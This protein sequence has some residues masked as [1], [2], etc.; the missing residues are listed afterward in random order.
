MPRALAATLLFGFLI[1]ADGA[2]ATDQT[3]EQVAV[4]AVVRACRLDAIRYCG[5]ATVRSA[6]NGDYSAVVPC[7]Q[8]YEPHLRESCRAVVSQYVR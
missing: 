3:P 5:L 4:N 7:F 8:R 1:V 6:L 2:L